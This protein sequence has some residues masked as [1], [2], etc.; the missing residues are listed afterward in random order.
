MAVSLRGSGVSGPVPLSTGSSGSVPTEGY[1]PVK[2]QPA[3][4]PQAAKKPAPKKTGK[5]GKK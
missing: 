2:K 4:K 5:T 3:R 1:V